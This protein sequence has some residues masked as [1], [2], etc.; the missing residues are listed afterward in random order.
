MDL[1]LS[2]EQ[3]L[4]RSSAREMLA[5]ECPM[6]HVRAMERDPRGYSPELWGKMAELGWM[7]IALPE[8]H[9]GLGYGFLDLCLL[10]EEM[11]RARLP[12]PF[13][14]TVVLAAMPILRFGS[15]EQRSE[16]LAA[17]AEGRR[18]LSTAALEPEGGWEAGAA[19][20]VATPDGDELVLSGT[21]LY[22]PYAGAADEL[23]VLARQGNGEEGA[24]TV[25]LVETAADG[26][27]HE[28]LETVGRDHLERVAFDGVR[29][30]R[31]RVLGEPGMGSDIAEAITLW[32]AAARCAEMVGGAQRVLETTVDYAK[33]RHQFGRP[34]GSFQAVQH[35]CANMSIDVLG[36]RFLTYEAAWSL[37]EAP[38]VAAEVVPMAKAWTGAAYRRV[39]QLGHQIHGAI[40]Y[41]EEE[42]LHLYLRHA[43]ASDLA[44]GDTDHHR[45]RVARQLGL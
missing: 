37:D 23:L 12:S 44:F 7:G 18:V 39:C 4:I 19:D 36:S 16:Y 6:E 5:A 35:H 42:D 1:R 26:I 34:I 25:L 11:G 41:T 40:G 45:E 2:E 8:N 3:E 10:L 20:T 33:E 29:V 17:I 38:A 31:D 27:A 43:I 13:V 24:L 22:V 9:G 32:G 30:G 15:D 28:P 14:P 21:K